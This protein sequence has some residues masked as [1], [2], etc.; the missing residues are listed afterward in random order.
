MEELR[1]CEPRVCL[2]RGYLEAVQTEVLKNKSNKNIFC[3]HERGREHEG[4]SN[5][6][7]RKLREDGVN[8]TAFPIWLR[9]S[10]GSGGPDPSPLSA[11]V[12][13]ES[14]EDRGAPKPSQTATP[15]R[16]LSV[17]CFSHA[18]VSSFLYMVIDAN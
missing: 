3:L 10:A 4:D 6:E 7:I 9:S 12:C 18:C 14:P 13:L 8:T 15:Q 2:R 11:S 5:G 1:F 17:L 16:A